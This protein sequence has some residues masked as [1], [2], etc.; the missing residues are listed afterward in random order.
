MSSSINSNTTPLLKD[1]VQH[2]DGCVD[3]DGAGVGGGGA[4]IELWAHTVEVDVLK[5][6]L[7]EPTTRSTSPVCLH[8]RLSTS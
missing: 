7:A 1:K 5:L 8:A 6:V 2:G 3:G 4:K